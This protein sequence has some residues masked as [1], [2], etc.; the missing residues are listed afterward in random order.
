MKLLLVG[1]G[2]REHALA[3]KLA[4]SPEVEKLFCLPG[5]DAISSVAECVG[6]DPLNSKEVADFCAREKISLVVVGPEGPLANGLADY[7]SQKGVRVFGPKRAGAQL[8]SSKY[9]AKQFM[10][11]HGISTARFCVL[12]TLVQAQEEIEKSRFPI[13]LK[14]DGLA[15]GKGVRICRSAEE[16]L[17]AAGDF[18][19]KRIFGESGETVLLEEFLEGREATLMA[20]CDGKDY[21][22]LPA[23]RDHKRLLERDAGE[24]TGGMGAYSPVADIDA[25]TLAVI[26]KEVFDKFI[27]GLAKD[28]LEYCG[29]IY[30]GLMLTREGPKVIEFNCRFGDPETQAL[31]PLIN[32]DLAD[33][34]YACSQGELKTKTLDITEGA[35]VSVVFSAHGY[36]GVPRKGDVITGID[37]AS[38]VFHSG[39]RKIHGEWKSDGGRVLS[40]CAVGPDLGSAS[41]AAYDEAAKIHFKDMHYRR[42]I[43]VL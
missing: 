21:L 23:C 17:A 33:V 32:T 2:G 13:V 37:A 40:V 24:N 41:A 7:L 1:S 4:Q 38:M 11:R 25:E 28:G 27:R 15:A 3:W 8:E 22:L 34:M 9:F 31:M 43:G 26:K 5:S 16:A 10:T 30:A 20:F 29:I 35:S 19:E 39:T 42:D 14:A 36:P 18:F 12:K 6:G